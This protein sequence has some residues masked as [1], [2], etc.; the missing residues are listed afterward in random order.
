MKIPEFVTGI[1]VDR[2]TIEDIKKWLMCWAVTNTKECSGECEICEYDVGEKESV[3]MGGKSF[4]YIQQLESRLAQAERERDAAISELKNSCYA[5][6]FV[7]KKF[8]D[9]PCE[10]CFQRGGKHPWSP[11]VRTKFEWRGVCPENTEEG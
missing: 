5:C 6:R 7:G 2:E 8:D 3:G 4:A 1:I 10:E 11:M 9:S